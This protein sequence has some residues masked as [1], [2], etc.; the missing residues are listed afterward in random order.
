MRLNVILSIRPSTTYSL[1]SAQP[2]IQNVPP[3]FHYMPSPFSLS[4]LTYHVSRNITHI[5]NKIYLYTIFFSDGHVFLYILTFDLFV[6]WRNGLLYF[7]PTYA[8]DK[9]HT[10][11]C[12]HVGFGIDSYLTE[13][14]AARIAC[15]DGADF[16]N[17]LLNSHKSANQDRVQNPQ[18]RVQ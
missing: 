10:L 16:N 5:W 12:T 4:V 17:P 14:T 3:H 1:F 18:N 13:E 11:S 2:T 9:V 7:P 8:I 6:R 15:D